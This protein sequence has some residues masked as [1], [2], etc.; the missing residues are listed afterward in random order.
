MSPLV[1]VVIPAYK[2]EKYI[3]ETVQSVIAQT[4]PNWEII[5]VDDG[6][7]DNQKEVIQALCAGDSRISYVYQENKGVSVARNLGISRAKGDLIALLDADDFW[8][9][10]NLAEKVAALSDE[11]VHFVYSDMYN[12]DKDLQITGVAESGKGE[13]I[14][15]NLLLWNGEV[16]PGPCSNLV[17]RR[18]CFSHPD[19]RFNPAL[20]TF[21]DQHLCALLA[22]S[23]KGK[24]IGKPLW[25]YRILSNSMSKN[26]SV[27]ERDCLLA[28]DL[29]RKE[30]L[31]SSKAFEKKCFANLYY[32]LGGSWWVNGGSKAKGM[33]YL[34]RAVLTYPP[35]ISK[36]AGKIF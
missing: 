28:Y 35:T 19:I 9:P 13:N 14:L 23:F 5:I 20:S 21:A 18:S 27:M 26:I 17:I 29:F 12:A 7:P 4:Y 32:I 22:R 33:G 31:F 25:K 16:I 3:A 24:H 15:E 8:L 30:G 1:S 11:S 34:L 6:S 2:A 10:E 36:V